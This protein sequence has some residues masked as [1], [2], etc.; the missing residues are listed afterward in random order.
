M[1]AWLQSIGDWAGPIAAILN[2]LIALIGVPV[3]IWKGRQARDAILRWFRSILGS[4]QDASSRSA[5]AA[6]DARRAADSVLEIRDA[7]GRIVEWLPEGDEAVEYL[8]ETNSRLLAQLVIQAK[9]HPEDFESPDL[10]RF[11][12]PA[13]VPGEDGPTTITGRH[14]LHTSAVPAVP[15]DEEAWS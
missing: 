3:A 12:I 7:Q 13:G 11:I 6:V 1:L 5:D 2:F 8:K 14:R 9:K 10:P 4:A 15:V